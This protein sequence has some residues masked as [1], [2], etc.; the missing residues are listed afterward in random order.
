MSKW[1]KNLDERLKHLSTMNGLGHL[2][3]SLEEM[4]LPPLN[5]FN[6]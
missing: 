6:K 3:M 2:C 4:M 5:E 1:M